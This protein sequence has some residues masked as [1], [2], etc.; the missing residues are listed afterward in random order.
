MGVERRENDMFPA[1]TFDGK[2][3]LKRKGD[4]K[5]KKSREMNNRRQERKSPY[6]LSHLPVSCVFQSLALGLVP[7]P[8]PA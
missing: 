8:A 4:K 1:L 2:E 5:K 3:K 7:S 6:L